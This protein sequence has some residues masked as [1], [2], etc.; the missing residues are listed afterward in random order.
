MSRYFRIETFALGSP[1]GGSWEDDAIAEGKDYSTAFNEAL[2][3]VQKQGWAME[4]KIILC[5]KNGEDVQ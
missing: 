1:G 4:V 2:E 3:Y 5:K